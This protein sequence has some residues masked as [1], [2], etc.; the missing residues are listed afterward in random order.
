MRQPF[1]YHT[2][3]PRINYKNHNT[4]SGIALATPINV[5]GGTTDGTLIATLS[6][7]NHIHFLD[8]DGAVTVGANDMY[9][10]KFFNPENFSDID[11]GSILRITDTTSSPSF[12]AGG[13]EVKVLRIDS[14]T[15]YFKEFLSVSDNLQNTDTISV[16]ITHKNFLSDVS[17]LDKRIN[18]Y[19]F[20]LKPE[21]H[22][23]SGTCN[24]SRL[25]SAKLKFDTSNGAAINIYAINYNVLRIMSGMG[26][27]AYSN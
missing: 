17:L 9:A 8:S 3:V 22:Q 20:A 18:V 2:V 11:V 13:D 5:F 23:P 15:V 25:D 6:T 10:I 27:L 16:K 12:I 7:A 14:K 26:G 1:D 21:E 19:S 24:F 4:H